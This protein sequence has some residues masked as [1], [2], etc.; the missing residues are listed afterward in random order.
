M[1]R[2]STTTPPELRADDAGAMANGY[3]ALFDVQTDIGGYFFETIA[4]GAFSD[5][6]NGDVRALIDH[7]HGR[8]IGRTA[9]G[10]L[11]LKEDSKGLFVEIDLPDTSDGRDLTVQLNRGDITGMSFGFNV[12]HDEWDESGDVPQRTIHKV[13][14]FE[15][16]AVAFPA[17]PETSIA[18]RSLESAR[19]ERK[20]KNFN[21][22]AHRLRLKTTLDLHQRSGSKA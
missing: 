11:R 20:Q 6:V 15:V 22:A 9:A 12:T 4:R 3:A 18:M 17:Y 7:D 13:E 8:V 5:A 1:E 19:T 14:L 21:A 10:T 2:R 16:S